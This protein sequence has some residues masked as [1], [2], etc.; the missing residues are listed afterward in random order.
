[1]Y[2][3]KQKRDR[4][5]KPAPKKEKPVAE[6]S[7]FHLAIYN[8]VEK[9]ERHCLKCGNKF[10]ARGKYIRRCERCKR[11]EQTASQLYNDKEEDE[12]DY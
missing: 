1:M 8:S 6:S 11:L 5:G 3:A 10:T 9:I 2:R 4:N 7:T 12:E